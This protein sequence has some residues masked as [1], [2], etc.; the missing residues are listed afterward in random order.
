M[1]SSHFMLGG[2]RLKEMESFRCKKF[3]KTFVLTLPTWEEASQQKWGGFSAVWH[4]RYLLVGRG[5]AGFQG[6]P[7]CNHGDIVQIPRCGC[8]NV[9][10]L[11]SSSCALIP[12]LLPSTSLIH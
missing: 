11:S 2:Y 8:R 10:R 3:M 6:H 12:Y 4:Q 7:G 9:R 5:I 1:T